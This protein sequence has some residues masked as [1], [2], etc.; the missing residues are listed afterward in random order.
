MAIFD[1][2]SLVDGPC[3]AQIM[4]SE[5]E[6]QQDMCKHL[7]L[8]QR[9]ITLQPEM[10]ALIMAETLTFP[11]PKAV[12]VTDPITPENMFN[13]GVEFAFRVLGVALQKVCQVG[14]DDLPPVPP[15]WPKG[16]L[17][18]FVKDGLI[19]IGRTG[20]IGTSGSTEGESNESG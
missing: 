2:W 13:A 9:K 12:K 11:E 14:I 16:G 10:A 1:E 17:Y 15:P 18:K 5:M 7:D 3:E 8:K 4:L 6:A 19:A 20:T